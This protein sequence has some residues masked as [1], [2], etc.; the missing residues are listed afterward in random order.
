MHIYSQNKCMV[1]MSLTIVPTLCSRRL[2]AA[3][4]IVLLVASFAL[5]FD[6]GVM[7]HNFCDGV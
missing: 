5:P 7:R 1:G 4:G 2:S 3:K 6:D